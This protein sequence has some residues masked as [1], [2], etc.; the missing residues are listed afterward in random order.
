MSFGWV[1]SH[2]DS[3]SLDCSTSLILLKFA[4]LA[5]LCKARDE[6]RKV[7]RSSSSGWPVVGISERK[8]GEIC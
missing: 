8:K 2:K 5:N 1:G 4:D 6:V 7:T 3:L